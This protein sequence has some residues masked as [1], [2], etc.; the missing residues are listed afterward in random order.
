MHVLEV[1]QGLCDVIL[2]A[3]HQ[4]QQ[5]REG[6]EEQHGDSAEAAA[7]VFGVMFTHEDPETLRHLSD[8][9]DVDVVALEGC[10]KAART[11]GVCCRPAVICSCAAMPR[12]SF[13]SSCCV[14][15]KDSK[16]QQARA[17]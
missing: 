10:E 17:R 5:A 11:G 12:V 13:Q 14:C 8:F 4:R 9:D 6:D 3:E 2:E 7:Q 16:A 1:Q 15:C